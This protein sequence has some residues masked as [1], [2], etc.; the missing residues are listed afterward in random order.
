MTILL[1]TAAGL[2][3]AFYAYVLVKFAKERYKEMLKRR[4]IPPVTPISC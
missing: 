3:C 1:C 2:S 4:N